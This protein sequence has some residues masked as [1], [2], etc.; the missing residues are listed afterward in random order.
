[1]SVNDAGYCISQKTLS[2]QMVSAE[3]KPYF[4]IDFAARPDLLF[5]EMDI[6]A[7]RLGVRPLS[8][9]SAKLPTSPLLFDKP[10]LRGEN[11]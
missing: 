9:R 5:A 6:E 10:Y 8:D 7:N 11:N 1:M 2:L 3:V 4:A